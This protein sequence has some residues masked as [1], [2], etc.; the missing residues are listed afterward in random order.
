MLTQDQVE[1]ALHGK[2]LVFLVG[3]P[4]SGT[5]WLQ[6]LLSR[7]PLV[8]TAQE[9]HLFNISLRSLVDEWNRIRQSGERIGLNQTLSE[10]EFRQLLRGASGYVL[11][12]IAQNKPSAAVILE[13]T[14]NHVQC[15]RE[16]LNIWP[17]AHFIHIIRDPRSV[18]TSLRIASR[19]WASHWASPKVTQN[20]E[21]WISDVTSGRQIRSATPNYQEVGFQELLTHGPDV[22]LRLLT[23]VGVTSSREECERYVNECNIENLKAGNLE[24]P[25]FDIGKMHKESF[26]TGSNESWRNELS[27]WEIALVERQAG[28]LMLELGFKPV[29]RGRVKLALLDLDRMVA[30]SLRAA[31]RRLKALVVQ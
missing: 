19:S 14:P 29:S 7:S 15:W 3:A 24:K 11:A 23:N 17:D 18:V 5:T 25:P 27:A 31:K 28:P 10:E 22:L 20:C 6:L 21:R 2:Q 16:I 12:R 9:T 13:K 8:A 1:N 30:H 4:R 26:R